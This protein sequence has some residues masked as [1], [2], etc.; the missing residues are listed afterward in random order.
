MAFVR[1]GFLLAVLAPSVF[2][3]LL[4]LSV[5]LLDPI[6][7]LLPG[8]SLDL[9][10]ELPAPDSLLGFT[11]QANI[12]GKDFFT[13]FHWETLDDPTHGRV[14]YVDQGVALSRNLTSATGSSFIMRAD[15]TTVVPK[16]ARGRDSNRIS[17]YST[18]SD[19]VLVLDVKHVPW[20][21]ATWPAFWTVTK[22]TWPRGGEIDVIEGINN[23][24]AN[25]ATLHTS[26]GCQ[27]QS[28]R[29]QSGRD[30][31]KHVLTHIYRSTV[32]TDCN[33]FANNNQGC[34]TSFRKTGSYGSALNAM[35]GGW[36][37]MK[38]MQTEGVYIWFWGRNDPSVPSEIKQNVLGIDLSVSPDKSWGTP[39]AHFPSTT[40][41]DFATHFDAHQIVFDLTF[42]GDWAGSSFPTSGCSQSSCEDYVNDNPHAFKTHLTTQ[43]DLDDM[44]PLIPTLALAFLSF[45]SSVFVIL[46]AVI[47]IL[48]PHPLKGRIALKRTGPSKS[49]TLSPADKVHVWLALCDLLALVFFSWEVVEESL[50]GPSDRSV[51]SDPASSVRLWVSLT[52]RQTCLLV[53]AAATLIYV[54]KG[55]PISFGA[56]Q[57]TIWVPTLVIAVT[58][59]ALAGVMAE[60]GE[61]SLFFGVV[62][63]SVAV[64]VLSTAAFTSLVATL[65][66][67]RRNLAS[68]SESTGVL[69]P[70]VEEKLHGPY[71]ASDGIKALKDGSSWITS[72]ASSRRN[73]ISSFSFSTTHSALTHDTARAPNPNSALCL[74]T[75]DKLPSWL[76]EPDVSYPTMTAWSFPTTCVGSPMPASSTALAHGQL[77]DSQEGSCPITPAMS[78]TQVLGES[79]FLST[80]ASL[81]NAEKGINGLSWPYAKC[82]DV[83]VW[84]VIAWLA[85]IWIPLGFSVPYLIII[86]LNEHFT[87]IAATIFLIL[88]VT[89]SAPLLAVNVLFSPIPIPS[90][91]FETRS[92]SS[93]IVPPSGN[94]PSPRELG[95]RYTRSG[96]VTVVESR[97][98][99]DVWLSKG[100]AIDGKNKLRRAMT[101]VSPA[102]KLSVL[103]SCSDSTTVRDYYSPALSARRFFTADH[104]GSSVGKLRRNGTQADRER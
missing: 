89:L 50:G 36:F 95:S 57:W 81:S 87:N 56:K 91:L 2:S 16:N 9:P 99:G 23:N 31:S 11:L 45:F 41:C 26:P 5:P 29:G 65:L 34:G 83:S 102:P 92:E 21:C 13:H 71:A 101:M 82:L 61:K 46:H 14:N 6:S 32:S 85:L 76:T 59:A 44:I 24:G 39:D 78:S 60:A 75:P 58:S 12:V 7:G 104:Q 80:T 79:R 73:S 54:R 27:M 48:P 52:V 40:S 4:P 28:H 62:G 69:H 88:S 98:S 25:R 90:G 66:A 30:S 74:S 17:S 37:V 49:R 93:I 1:T 47:P 84:R 86:S 70:A 10:P 103:P 94:L 3:S 68:P 15:Y 38:R 22:S 43:Y 67:I 96:S 55:K 33:A 63:F 53:V 97:R 64:A 51:A 35:G 20:G 100:D 77:P 19:S 72:N 8:S 18:Y 42:C